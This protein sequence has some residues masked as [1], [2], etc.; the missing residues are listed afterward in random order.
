MANDSVGWWA[1]A[2]GEGGPQTPRNWVGLVGGCK[3]DTPCVRESEA[4]ARGRPLLAI[5]K[6][7]P[8]PDCLLT[9]FLEAHG[10]FGLAVH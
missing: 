5:C 8:L 1:L 9:Q 6:A 2:F 7:T 3:I 4:G 10:W